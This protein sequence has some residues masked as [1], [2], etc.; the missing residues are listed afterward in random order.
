MQLETV[1]AFRDEME[2][3]AAFPYQGK[4]TGK[5]IAKKMLRDPDAVRGLNRVGGAP[6]T[7]K[8]VNAAGEAAA[9]RAVKS[10]PRMEKAMERIKKTP[11][12]E[13]SAHAAHENWFDSQGPGG[14]PKSFI[15]RKG[16]WSPNTIY[17]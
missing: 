8:G 14:Y 3:I 1:Q 6:L 16:K 7:Q 15:D 12:A 11:G 10:S 4:L 5:I 9:E 2:K 17:G 13:V